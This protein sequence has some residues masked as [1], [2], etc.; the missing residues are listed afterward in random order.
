[1]IA[2]RWKVNLGIALS[3]LIVTGCTVP[4]PEPENFR[5][6]ELTP[7]TV[8]QSTLISLPPPSMKVPVAVYEFADQTGQFSPSDNVQ[9]LSRAV[10][11]GA[12]AIL[13]KALQDAGNRSWFTVVE[14][15]GLNNLLKER[16]I[17]REMRQRYLGERETPASALPPLLFAGIL[18]E[19]GIIGYD[20]NTL[21]G[22]AGARFLGIGGD[23]KYRQNTVTIYLRAVSVKTGEVLASVTTQKTLS[24]VAV[25]G[26]AFKFISFDQLLEIEAGITTNEPG[27]MALR[28]AIEKSVGA[29]IM[30]GVLVGIWSF[31]DPNAA[32]ALLSD[33]REESGIAE[34]EA[35][36]SA[37]GN[38]NL[39]TASRAIASLMTVEAEVGRPSA[40][41][42]TEAPA[43]PGRNTASDGTYPTP[44]AT[45]AKA[46]LLRAQTAA[47]KALAASLS[48]EDRAFVCRAAIAEIMGHPVASIS[49]TLQSDGT[50]RTEYTRPGDS[51]RWVNSCKIEG[52]PVIWA[53]VEGGSVGHW[54]LQPNAEKIAFVLNTEG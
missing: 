21:T 35:T 51:T 43:R 46:V 47:A 15:A 40:S 6:P 1:M 10:T 38:H 42:P 39:A 27:M 53:S 22:G 45:S 3:A 44:G 20:S 34:I 5:A 41:H 37:A 36:I 54:R 32:A 48:D 14:R 31:A 52:D 9:T 13:I 12:A 16:Q 7:I 29:I 50:I 28:Q 30:E 4:A 23:V 8:S 26:G 2:M 24:S 25:Q 49:A 19:G 17:I 11:Q 18:F 33:Y